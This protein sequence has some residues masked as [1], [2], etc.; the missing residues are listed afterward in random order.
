MF[1][2][3]AG[4]FDDVD[5]ALTWHPGMFNSSITI[6]CLSILKAFFKF[7]GRAA[8]ASTNPYYGCCALDAV[9]LMNVGVNY[10]RE[11]MIPDARIH[12]IITNGG[13]APN[14]VPAFAESCYYIRAPKMSDVMALYERV[15][16]IAKGAAMMT[17]TEFEAVFVSAC[18]GLVRNDTITDA[19]YAQL[20]QIK[21]PTYTQDEL[22][23][24]EEIT[25]T[26]PVTP[27]LRE[28]GKMIGI[29]DL[30]NSPQL[31]GKLLADG[32]LPPIK[33]DLI[34]PGSTDVADVSQVVPLSQIATSC[35]VVGTSLHTWQQVA[36]VG[37]GI[38]HKGMI[39]E[40]QVLAATAID[41]LSNPQLLESARQEFYERTK[42]S[43]YVSPIPNDV[44]P[45]PD[46]QLL[47]DQ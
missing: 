36:Q 5:L 15:Q 41:F 32:V 25:K 8:H 24:A 29:P 14:I 7:H 31:K 13:E 23:F 30:E 17:G 20:E 3:K 42:N 16:K 1:M 44:K 43:P 9:E 39:Y 37:M 28:F 10:L 38:G 47:I 12:T 22:D 2:V 26:L 40:G 35:G 46:S 4:C 11:H 21:P 33:T 6:R 27:F 34:G 45:F 19:L 18:S